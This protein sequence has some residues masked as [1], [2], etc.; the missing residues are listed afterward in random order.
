LEVIAEG[1]S[2]INADTLDLIIRHLA[3]ETACQPD[4]KIVEKMALILLTV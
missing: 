3:L 4:A 1:V 2:G